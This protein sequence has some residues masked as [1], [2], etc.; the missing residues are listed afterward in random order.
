MIFGDF[1]EQNKFP[2]GFSWKTAFLP[3]ASVDFRRK[4][5]PVC[6]YSSKFVV[7]RTVRNGGLAHGGGGQQQNL[8]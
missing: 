8:L 2:V 3:F 7:F 4:P 6:P 5:E 1:C